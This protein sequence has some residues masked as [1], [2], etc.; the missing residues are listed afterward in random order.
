[1]L[2]P[3]S[4]PELGDPCSAQEHA[5]IDARSL[6]DVYDNRTVHTCALEHVMDLPALT[7]SCAKAKSGKDSD[8]RDMNAEL[9]QAAPKESATP[10]SYTHLT[11]PTIC[12][13]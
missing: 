10:V 9:V 5:R 3:V 6:D 8:A 7:Q 13:V 1:M 4:S 2:Q 12:S 11:L